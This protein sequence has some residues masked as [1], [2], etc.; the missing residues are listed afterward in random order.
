MRNS[1]ANSLRKWTELSRMELLRNRRRAELR[2]E[3]LREQRDCK[4]AEMLLLHGQRT[5]EILHWLQMG[6]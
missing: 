5:A 3:M 2:G 6:R 1:R 4:E